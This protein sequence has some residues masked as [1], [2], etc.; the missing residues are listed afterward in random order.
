MAKFDGIIT[1]DG[2]AASGKSSAGLGLAR[3][4]NIA[5]ISS[6]YFYRA[7]TFLALEHGINPNDGTGLMEYLHGQDISLRVS[8]ALEN[9]VFVGDRDISSYLHSNSVDSNVSA[10]AKHPALR[11]WANEKLTHT[12]PPFVI[13]GRDMGKVVFPRADYKFYLTA[14]AEVRARRRLHERDGDFTTLVASLQARDKKDA[15]QLEP[16][17]DAIHIDSN[18]LNLEE[19]VAKMLSYLPL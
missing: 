6:G 7:A 8:E 11:T 5:F 2:P 14:R 16:A 15:K 4:L 9:L 19:V 1:I 10:I 3:A 12:A 13:E 17:P 18:D